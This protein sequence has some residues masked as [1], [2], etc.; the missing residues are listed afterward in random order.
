M[1]EASLRARFQNQQNV[2]GLFEESSTVDD[3]D[4]GSN[5]II[6]CCVTSM[7]PTGTIR[8]WV[9]NDDDVERDAGVEVAA[10]RARVL[11]GDSRVIHGRIE[12]GERQF[13][14]SA[15]GDVE[16]LVELERLV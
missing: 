8:R 12:P 1:K 6:D 9:A 5:D 15:V 11:S 7:T 10:R 14:Q 16:V 13:G 4:D 3:D 2:S